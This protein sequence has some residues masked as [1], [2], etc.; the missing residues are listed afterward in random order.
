MQA[1]Q[2]SHNTKRKYGRK[3]RETM[4]ESG[5]GDPPG[6][7]RRCAV[8][9]VCG[10]GCA[11]RCAVGPVCGA[12]CA[13]RGEAAVRGTE[14]VT[15]AAPSGGLKCRTPPSHCP[16]G[17]PARSSCSMTRQVSFTRFT[18]RA[19]PLLW[20]EQESYLITWFCK[21]FLV[22]L[23]FIFLWRILYF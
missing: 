4:M 12:G 5:A 10:A 8:G 11:R 13:R 6:S 3:T 14:K 15:A 7:A 23:Y 17:P 1:W 9:P 20:K 2:G 22:C 18:C 19:K 16:S 21:T